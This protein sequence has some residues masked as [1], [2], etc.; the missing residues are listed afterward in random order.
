VT[1]LQLQLMLLLLFEFTLLFQS[2]QRVDKVRSDPQ[3][4]EF[5]AAVLIAT[6]VFGAST[7]K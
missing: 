4:I 3:R 6:S 5:D 7:R 1:L 2:H